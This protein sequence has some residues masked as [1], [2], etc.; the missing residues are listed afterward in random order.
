[1]IVRQRVREGRVVNQMAVNSAIPDTRKIDRNSR[2]SPARPRIVKAAK[3][4]STNRIGAYSRY[5]SQE[6]AAIEQTVGA[7]GQTERPIPAHQHPKQIRQFAS[8]CWGAVE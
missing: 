1:M 6:R 2:S 5:T 4:L 3:A 8:R 7:R